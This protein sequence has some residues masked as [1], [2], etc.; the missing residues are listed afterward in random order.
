MKLA[1][2]NVGLPREVEWNGSTVR[3]G[4]FKYPTQDAVQV[5]RLNILGD[6]QEDLSVHGGPNKAVG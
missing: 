2:V 1:S 6:K 3:T 4:I 5:E